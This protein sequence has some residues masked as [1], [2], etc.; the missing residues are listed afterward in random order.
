MNGRAQVSRLTRL[1]APVIAILGALAWSQPD[2]PGADLWWHL[3]T[4]R[5]ILELGSVPLQDVYSYTFAGERWMNPEWLWALL[6]WSLYELHPQTIAWF[7]LAVVSTIFA[8]TYLLALRQSGSAL[9]AGVAVWLAAASAHWFIDI[10][11]HLFT[12]LFVNIFLLTRDRSWAP[13]LW[14]VLTAVWGN[15]HGGV[16]FGI[17]AIGLYALVQTVGDRLRQGRWNVSWQQWIGVALSLLTLGANPFGFAM[18]EYPADFLNPDSPFRSLVEWRSASFSLDPGNYRGRFWLIASTSALMA[19]LVARRD[20][21]M[22][23]L[24]AVSFVMA[25]SARK[26]IPLFAIVVAPVIAIGVAYVRRVIVRQWNALDS[27]GASLGTTLAAGAV[28]VLLWHDVRLH[29]RLLERWTKSDLFPEAALRY[30]EALGSPER[31]LCQYPWGGYVMLH[32]PRM[33]VFIDGR[34]KTVYDDRIYRDY[35]SI[36]RGE[37]ALHDHVARYGADAALFIAWS[38]PVKQLM[39]PPSS[40]RLVY[41]DGLAAVLLPPDSPALARLPRWDH[42]LNGHFERYYIQGEVERRQGNLDEAVNNFDRAIELN[43]LL[44]RAH[45][46]VAEVY[47]QRND[48]NGVAAAIERGIRAYPRRV[49]DFRYREGLIYQRAHDY[50][51]ALRAY[52]LAVSTGPF[53]NPEGIERAIEMLEA[54][55]AK[56]E[57]RG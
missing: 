17:G 1:L 23:I 15:A 55:L 35:H 9:G 50:E 56:R 32:A 19:P 40:W 36:E 39:K 30:L 20:P 27:P 5:T 18:L 38:E 53:V 47:G 25:L 8:L 10:R 33:K 54:E 28:A 45:T 51:K 14:P 31:L 24:G 26:F 48:L 52:R 34:A 2:V 12:L 21:Y 57:Q 44:A 37:P 3:A 41:T 42:V 6:Y 7:N 43:P 29:P 4:G 22:L 49:E 13:W 16:L 46:K 11:P